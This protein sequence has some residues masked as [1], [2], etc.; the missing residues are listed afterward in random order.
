MVTCRF[1]GLGSGGKSWLGNR[2]D[3]EGWIP[4]DLD[5]LASPGV[6]PGVYEI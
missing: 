3:E 6:K 4:I 2:T 5:K 1:V